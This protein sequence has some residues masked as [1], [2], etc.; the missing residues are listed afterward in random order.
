MRQK[1]LQ[2]VRSAL[3][4]IL[5]KHFDGDIGEALKKM[6]APSSLLSRHMASFRSMS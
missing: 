6:N 3:T 5:A 1:K 4:G 2:I